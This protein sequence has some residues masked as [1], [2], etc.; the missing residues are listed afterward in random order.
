MQQQKITTFLWF[1]TEAEEAAKFYVSVFGGDSK[2]LSVDRLGDGKS[3]MS[4]S[5]QLAGQRYVALNGNERFRFN[6]S[7]SLLVSCEGQAEVDRFWDALVAG[8]KPSRCG[9]LADK[10]GVSWQIIPDGLM[11][12]LHDKDPAKTGRLMQAFMA[13]QKIDLSALE[14]ARRG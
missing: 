10:F 8:G 4:V 11:K 7:I 6:E 5:F 12:L 1:E 3:V 2:V 9:W 13:M 14:R